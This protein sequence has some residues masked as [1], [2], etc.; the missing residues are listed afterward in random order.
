MNLEMGRYGFACHEGSLSASLSMR[1]IKKLCQCRIQNFS[2]IS[3]PRCIACRRSG[4]CKV[5]GVKTNAVAEILREPALLLTTLYVDFHAPSSLR[6]SHTI[7]L[8]ATTP[9]LR[10]IN[11][12]DVSLQWDHIHLPHLRVLHLTAIRPTP[13]GAQLFALLKAAPEL[14]K[15]I[16][17]GFA[18]NLLDM[19]D[20]P[21]AD[22]RGE[23]L[24]L[25]PRLY[26]IFLLQCPHCLTSRLVANIQTPGLKLLSLSSVNP[27]QLGVSG[28]DTHLYQM[29]KPILTPTSTIHITYTCSRIVLV[30]TPTP[31]PDPQTIGLELPSPN[32]GSMMS[33]VARFAQSLVP[34]SGTLK[35]QVGGE[36]P[37]R[38]EPASPT[39][40]SPP[41]R[42][43]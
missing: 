29:I 41:P 31:D 2:K 19:D 9:L 39:L 8:S 43:I 18:P 7:E 33:I 30:G 26:C 21:A 1:W 34:S 20:N 40:R 3:N 15:L 12:C 25:L 5:D 32:P 11:L 28:P 16:L 36:I 17:G 22:R 6:P 13:T 38:F 23:G 4:L 14:E 24:A 42:I 27:D 10:H 35:L 37:G